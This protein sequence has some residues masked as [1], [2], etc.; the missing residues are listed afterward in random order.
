MTIAAFWPSSPTWTKAGER[1]LIF[2][3]FP[4]SGDGWE[5]KAE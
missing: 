3:N 1:P 5:A 4:C 2:R